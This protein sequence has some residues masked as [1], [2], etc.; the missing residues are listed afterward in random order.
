MVL[1]A[2]NFTYVGSYKAETFRFYQRILRGFLR[3]HRTK[4]IW[5]KGSGKRK[6]YLLMIDYL[7]KNA[8]KMFSDSLRNGGY[9]KAEALDPIQIL[10]EAE[11]KEAEIAGYLSYGS[12]ELGN[13]DE[14]WCPKDSYRKVTINY[15]RGEIPEY[16]CD[17]WDGYRC[18]YPGMTKRAVTLR[19]ARR[20]TKPLEVHANV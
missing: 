16:T 15:C 3:W 17:A 12:V 7:A 2:L 6:A 13:Y 14:L 18:I 10:K 19:E 9:F 20:N 4:V 5:I 11:E 8:K 1:I